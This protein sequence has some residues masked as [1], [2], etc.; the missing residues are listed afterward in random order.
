MVT[1]SAPSE[2][3][4]ATVFKL[5]EEFAALGKKVL[6]I[7]ADLRKPKMHRLFNTNNGMGLS[8]LLTNVIQPNDIVEIFRPTHSPY[9]TLLT[10]GT[11]PPNPSDMLMSQKMGL[12][13][14]YCAKKYDLVILDTPPV[15]GLSDSAIL[16][17][18][19]DGTLLIVSSKQVPRKA[20]KA[21]LKRLKSVG[22]NIMGVAMT[23]F[24]VSK[25]DYNYA[26]RYMNYNYY[27]YESQNPKLEASHAISGRAKGGGGTKEI[28]DGLLETNSSF[29]NS[30]NRFF[31]R[32]S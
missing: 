31:K 11:I 3:K 24:S 2:G 6:I 23:K 18:L 26:Y 4:S 10:A 19:V 9:I 17:R 8:N 28:P 7:D 30:I 5:A 20:A 12:T 27:T 15:M 21:A 25:T 16:S 1:S 32:F 13:I 29:A 14:H 22:A